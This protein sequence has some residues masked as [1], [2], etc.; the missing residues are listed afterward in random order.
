MNYCKL[1]IKSKNEEINL[2]SRC[3][4]VLYYKVWAPTP[5]EFMGFNLNCLTHSS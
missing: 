5:R 4:G 3:S 2:D 1:K